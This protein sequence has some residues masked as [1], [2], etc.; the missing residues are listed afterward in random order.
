MTRAQRNKNPGNLKFAKQEGAV[1]QDDRGFAVFKTDIDGWQ[2]LVK[3]IQLDAKRGLTIERFVK[4]YAPPTENDSRAYCDFI[5]KGLK[6]L[7]TEAV[8]SYHSAA[9]AGLIAWY[10]GY[11]REI[12]DE[13]T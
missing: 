8:S 1:G 2:A 12:T 6:A 10:E 4:K 13:T 9:I 7:P 11:F 5:C 3:Q